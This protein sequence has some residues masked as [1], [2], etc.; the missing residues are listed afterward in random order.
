MFRIFQAL[1]TDFTERNW[2]S[3]NRNYAFPMLP[4]FNDKDS[5]SDFTYFD[6]TGLMA[7][8]LD[9]TTDGPKTFLLEIKTSKNFERGFMFSS[10]QFKLVGILC[11]KELMI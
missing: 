8:I 10:T 11:H 7:A 5:S 6:A 2:T 1:L 9:L 4:K 3:S